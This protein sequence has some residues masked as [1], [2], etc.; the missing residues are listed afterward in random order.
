MNKSQSRAIA[1][2]RRRLRERGVSRYEVRGLTA[3]KE[4]VR[5]LAKRLSRGD[6]TAAELRQ[7]VARKIAE[8]QPLRKGGVLAV[9]RRSP[10]VGSE[11]S[12]EREVHHGRKTNL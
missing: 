7:E 8:D 10:L 5:S 12:V 11:L 3:D 9:L 1:N 2:H 4:L 6:A